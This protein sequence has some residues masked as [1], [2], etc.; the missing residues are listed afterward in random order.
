MVVG[1]KLI[2]NCMDTIMKYDKNP[3][4]GNW[5]CWIPDTGHAYYYSTEKQAITFCNNVNNA[6]KTGVLKFEGGKIVR[7]N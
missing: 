7:M 6:F 4:T 5:L 2:L 1:S 3:L